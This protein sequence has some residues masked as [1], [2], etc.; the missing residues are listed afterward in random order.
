MSKPV[1]IVGAGRTAIGAFGGAFKNYSAIKLGTDCAKGVMKKFN[2]P[3]EA[4]EEVIIGNILSAGLGMN[5][6]RQ[7]GINSGIPNTTP[8][9]TVN[10]VC[11]SG[12]KAVALGA[13]SIKAED[14]H[15]V[16]AGGIEN[17]SMAP[18]YIPNARW[19]LRMG[20]AELVDH[21][22]YEGLTDVFNQ[23]HMGVTAEFIAEK[24]NIS[25]E[26]QDKFA[27]ESQQKY[28]KAMEQDKFKNE[29]IP[30]SI[31][32]RKGEPIVVDK[33]EHPRPDV[34]MEKLAK[35]RPA[36]KKDGTVT[37][38]NASGINDGAAIVFLADE[39]SIKKYNLTPIAEI[40]T[41][42]SAGVEPMEMG[43]GPVPATLKALE[44]ANMKISDIDLFELNEA[45]AVQSI[46]V[47]KLLKEK[48]GNFDES[49]ININGGAIALGHPIG[50]SGA[51]I[52]T[53]LLYALKDKNLKT[54]LASLCIGGGQGITM[55]V[56]MI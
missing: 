4:I 43:L 55:I 11:G 39:E 8:M 27:F 3:E 44:K 2:I 52:L 14:K 12:L 48:L 13:N 16:M 50:A 22:I 45:F 30:I 23:V 54:G 20:N 18:Y 42:A 40:I 35:M 26:E 24:Y 31:P 25:R 46:G 37:A 10:K 34:T 51:R 28:K 41:Y 53:T 29:I 9:F 7:V 21:M 17:M 56:K 15:L 32:Q 6:A 5:P 36:F 38:G 19:G 49:K 33:D 1:Y 47:I